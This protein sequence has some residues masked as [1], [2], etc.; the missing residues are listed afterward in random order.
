M[1][2]NLYDY[3]KVIAILLMIVDHIGYF[4]YPDMIELR[5]I[6]RWSFPLFFMLIGW[7][8][9][10]RIGGGLIFCA[11]AVQGV[12]RGVSYF[13][14]YDLRQLNILPAVILVKLF[15]WVLQ[16]FSKWVVRKGTGVTKQAIDIYSYG[17]GNKV[18]DAMDT[19]PG[20]KTIKKTTLYYL[21]RTLWL[22]G[23]VALMVGL[24]FLIPASKEFVEY[25][26]MTLGMALL[27]LTIRQYKSWRRILWLPMTLGFFGLKSVNSS[28][29]FSNTQRI[30]A[31]V[32]WIAWMI[33]IRVL[34]YKNYSMKKFALRDAFVLFLSKYAVWIY[35]LH[36]LGLLAR[37]VIK[38]STQTT[39]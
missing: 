25:G 3:L 39:V 21:L 5:V 29:P 2:P 18:L 17:L 35:V 8:K 15:I 10:T 14:G 16:S 19:V 37:I 36:F 6:W 7:N 22:L 26:T 30:V 33:S 34:S 11:L 28:F 31:Y 27:G 24:Y 9:S 12:L 20:V 23:I 32:G 38:Q 13:K 1:R 4:L